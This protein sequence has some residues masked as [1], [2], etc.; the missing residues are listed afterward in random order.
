MRHF[1]TVVFLSLMSF[2]VARTVAQDTKYPPV[3]EYLM[4]Q[5]AEIALAK[6]AAP[7]NISGKATIK[8]LT[9]SG[10]RVVHEGDNG[11]VCLVMRG[12]GAPTY[13]PMEL[14][15]LVF[16]AKL[17]APICFDAQASQT[18]LPYYE[19]RHKLGLEGKTPEEIT[20]GIQ[21][22]YSTGALP[23]RDR[24]SFAYMWSADEPYPTTTSYPHRLRASTETKSTRARAIT[25][26][27]IAAI[28]PGKRSNGATFT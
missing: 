20:K 2:G 26:A 8:V 4:P 17:R 11:F 21:A 24:V 7:D 3:S 23:K 6:S 10:F 15:N 1:A 22:A 13:T 19:L 18:V 9:A 16:D 5:D 27:I 25:C 12:F 28:F 14:R